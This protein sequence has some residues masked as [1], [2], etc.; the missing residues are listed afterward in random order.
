MQPVEIIYTR[1]D[2]GTWVVATNIFPNIVGEGTSCDEALYDLTH[3][4]RAIID[5]IIGLQRNMCN[6]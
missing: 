6:E 3:K 2:D 4:L 1:Q 5:T